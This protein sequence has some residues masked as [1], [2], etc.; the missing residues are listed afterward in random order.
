MTS[1]QKKNQERFKRVVKRAA[2]IRRANPRLSQGEAVKK[3]WGELKRGKV[4][5]SAKPAAKKKTARRKKA[6][7]HKDT[8]S[9]NV[10]ISVVSGVKVR[11]QGGA[12]LNVFMKRTLRKAGF[13]VPSEISTND[14]KRLYKT[15]TGRKP[16]A[17]SRIN[18]L[19]K[20]H[21]YQSAEKVFADLK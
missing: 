14:L 10:K 18:R 5:G 15:I 21:G 2:A 16:P 13:S 19:L 12:L 17:L 1:A 11:T 8:K 9:H 20:K 4:S 7:S 6:I 3:A